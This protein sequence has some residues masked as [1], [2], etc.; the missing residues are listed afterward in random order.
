MFYTYTN[1]QAPGKR[2]PALIFLETAMETGPPYEIKIEEFNAFRADI[3]NLG[4]DLKETTVPHLKHRK[5]FG[6]PRT[7]LKIKLT[8][9][10]SQPE[11]DV[12]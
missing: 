12:I 9:F 6:R 7:V 11:L 5:T 10:R 3:G 2:C 4:A 8:H 1:G